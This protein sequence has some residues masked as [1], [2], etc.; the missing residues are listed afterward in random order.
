MMHTLNAVSGTHSLNAVNACPGTRAW[1]PRPLQRRRMKEARDAGPPLWSADRSSP[2]HRFRAAGP[3]A[4][5]T[6]QQLWPLVWIPVI[7]GTDASEST[8]GLYA[9]PT[10][11]ACVGSSPLCQLSRFASLRS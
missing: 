4:R 1:Q 11:N 2:M 7:R 10:C 3:L 6:L 8:C 9:K 5:L